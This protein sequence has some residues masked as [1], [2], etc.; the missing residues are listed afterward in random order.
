MTEVSERG[1]IGRQSASYRQGLVLGLTMAE[2]MLLLVFCLLISTGVVLSKQ[3]AER[4][5]LE[6]ALRQA[7]IES[8]ANAHVARLLQENP[9]LREALERRAGSSSPTAID[10]FWR[11]LVDALAVTDELE[12]NGLSN[13]NARKDAQFLAEAERLHMRG[14]VLKDAEANASLVAK[15]EAALG[16]Q[17]VSEA[18]IL[19]AVEKGQFQDKMPPGHRWPPIIKLSEADGYFF[20][21]GS[22]ELEPK[23]KEVLHSSVVDSLLKTAKEYDVDIIEVVGHTDEQ[24]IAPRTSNLDKDLAFSIDHPDASARLRPADNAGL[25]LARAVAVVSVLSSDKRLSPYKILPLSGAQLIQTNETLSKGSS[26]GNVKER[27]RI[28][29]RLRKSTVPNDVTSSTH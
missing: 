13:E 4:L 17:P 16:E 21:N 7:L 9:Q 12:R 19:T 14:L 23:F 22:A 15:I 24:P 10:E 29:I 18:T 11:K 28:E 5:R 1:Q 20:A 26:P 2:V 6:Q 25:G 27:R 8:D 3:N